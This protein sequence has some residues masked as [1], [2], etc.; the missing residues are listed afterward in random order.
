MSAKQQEH[1]VKEEEERS[2]SVQK[3]QESVAAP[4][5][6]EKQEQEGPM[7]APGT[8]AG[9][10]DTQEP[11][12]AAVGD[13]T[14]LKDLCRNL[15]HTRPGEDASPEKLGHKGTPVK[16]GSV[17]RCHADTH[18][19]KWHLEKAGVMTHNSPYAKVRMMEGPARSQ[20]KKYTHNQLLV[21]E[22]GGTVAV[23]TLLP[24][25]QVQP[26]RQR[27]QWKSWPRRAPTLL[28]LLLARPTQRLLAVSRRNIFG[29]LGMC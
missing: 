28:R 11:P 19:D 16:V 22:A 14:R 17:V 29:D 20:E 5:V 24:G 26:P 4:A 27:T 8:A 21:F 18:K 3:Q 23:P 12:Q 1:N 6:V 15:K 10:G 13:S 7:A 2:A 9:A 25:A